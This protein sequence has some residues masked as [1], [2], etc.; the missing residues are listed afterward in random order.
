[1][2][3]KIAGLVLA[4]TAAMALCACGNTGTTTQAT[5]PQTATATPE[6]AAAE[7]AAET[8][9]PEVTKT[10]SGDIYLILP[11]EV[12]LSAQEEAAVMN[13]AKA[14]GYQVKVSVSEGD[15][16]KQTLAFDTAINEHAA[17]IICD[18]LD[19]DMTAASVQ[20]AKEAGI[21]TVLMNRGIS[22][23]GSAAAQILTDRKPCFPK[24]AELFADQMGKTGS[25]AYI[26]TTANAG[27]AEE[28]R[29]F[30]EAMKSYESMTD[31]GSVDADEYNKE[32]VKETIR[33]LLTEK[34]EISA[35][36]CGNGVQA[37]AAVE[38]VEE[39]TAELTIICL[40]GN[41]DEI[42][43]LILSGKIHAS[44]VKPSDDLGATAIDNAVTYLKNGST[45]T[46]EIMYYTGVILTQ[47]ETVKIVSP[48]PAPSVTVTPSPVPSGAAQAGDESWVEVEIDDSNVSG[49]GSGSA[50]ESVVISEDGSSA[51]SFDVEIV[52]LDNLDEGGEG[53]PEDQQ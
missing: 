43:T 44:V 19:N 36:V 40:D 15:T 10:A 14:A 23:A 33:Q 50:D 7:S 31:A 20:K 11:T 18:N 25:Y 16:A 38:V 13:G 28:V 42:S 47:K 21:P 53:R 46:N 4:V 52:D 9:T 22:A 45:G 34:P 8:P 41:D 26:C 1:M 2:R 6:P 27:M 12:G 49:N 51:G 24:L 39:Q 17:L 5:E 29:L 32:A 48:T 35:L 37:R 3:K 30:S